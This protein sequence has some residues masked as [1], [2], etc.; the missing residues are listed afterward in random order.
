MRNIAI[1][2]VLLVALAGLGYFLPAMQTTSPRTYGSETYGIS[3]SYPAKYLVT[4]FEEGTG[5]RG[6]HT[7]VL[8]EDTEENRAILAGERPGTEGPPTIV[9]GIFQN[10]LDGYTAESFVKNTSFSNFKLSDGALEEATVGG[11]GALRYDATG[12]Y[13][14]KNAVVARTKY[15]YMFTAYYNSP[16]DPILSDFE[17]VLAS[18]SFN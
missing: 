12:L 4:E 18:V 1:A 17:E 5:E 13:E 16:D 10:D 15:V 3:F 14:N 6:R 2:F 9:V 11:E 8:I 7:L